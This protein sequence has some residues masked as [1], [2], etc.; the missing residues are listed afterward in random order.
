MCIR[1]RDGTKSVMSPPNPAT[2]LTRLELRYIFSA[3]VV[4]KTVS[5]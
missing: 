2:C 5:A 4:K 1:D 3:L